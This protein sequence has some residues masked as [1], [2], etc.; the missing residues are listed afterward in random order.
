MS[1]AGCILINKIN[2]LP[3]YSSA[4]QVSIEFSAHTHFFEHK[5]QINLDTEIIFPYRAHSTLFTIPI[6]CFRRQHTFVFHGN[7]ITFFSSFVWHIEHRRIYYD[8]WSFWFI[9][10]YLYFCFLWNFFYRLFTTSSWGSNKREFPRKLKTTKAK[11]FHLLY[12]R[13][14]K[15]FLSAL[16][17]AISGKS[18]QCVFFPLTTTKDHKHTSNFE[19]KLK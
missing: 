1:D 5:T 17:F 2:Q 18:D 16:W 12:Y 14:L 6:P 7:G 9:L 11:N 3:L 13:I 15:E 8:I 10:I 19:N 4:I